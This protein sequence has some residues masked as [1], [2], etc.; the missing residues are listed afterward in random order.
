MVSQTCCIVSDCEMDE[1]TWKHNSGKVHVA[2]VANWSDSTKNWPVT[3]IVHASLASLVL[4]PR[5]QAYTQLLKFHACSH[6]VFLQTASCKCLYA[7]CAS[8]LDSPIMNRCS[9]K[10]AVWV[11]FTWSRTSFW[12]CITWLESDSAL[13]HPSCPAQ[14]HHHQTSWTYLH[15]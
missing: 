15:K 14:L 13:A 1:A 4:G 6:L 12:W 11:Q 9:L 8:W 10:T 7:Q 2:T 5:N 3:R